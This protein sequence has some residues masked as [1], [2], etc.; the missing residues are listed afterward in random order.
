MKKCTINSFKR[1]SST[2]LYLQVG[3]KTGRTR[4]IAMRSRQ[5]EEIPLSIVATTEILDEIRQKSA[6][7]PR[8]GH[9]LLTTTVSMETRSF[10][11]ECWT[12]LKK[13]KPE[14]CIK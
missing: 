4:F 9:V 10:I 12:E 5:L 8:N 11:N 13:L 6:I 2:L 7:D 14:F 3:G 1:P